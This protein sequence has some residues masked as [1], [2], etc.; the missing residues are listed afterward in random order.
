VIQQ[1]LA[2]AGQRGTTAVGDMTNAGATQTVPDLKD[3]L[4]GDSYGIRG[5]R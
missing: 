4:S 2:E 3:M 5:K 1:L